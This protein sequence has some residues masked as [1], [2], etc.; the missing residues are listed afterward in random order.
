MIYT[1]T[2]AFYF[3]HPYNNAVKLYHYV[4]CP[5]CLRIRMVLGNLDIPWKSVPLDYHDEETPLRL[6]G[7]KMLPI[8]EWDSGERMNESLDI[9]ARLDSDNILGRELVTEE[10]NILLNQ[11][12]VPLFK[13]SMPHLIW[14]KEFNEKSRNYFQ[15]KKEKTRG[16]FLRLVAHQ[17]E[18]LEEL[19]RILAKIE[20]VLKN[21]TTYYASDKI[22]LPDI[23]LA[24]H[25]WSL[26]IVPEFQFSPILHNYL[27]KVKK[28]CRFNYQEDLW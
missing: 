3:F 22:T 21:S 24:S 17:Q 14:T 13:I 12:A 10:F 25:L 23:L 7:K 6:M 8:V 5:F 26:Y 9:M 2:L 19:N 28:E 4:H 20:P 27:Q 15:R 1:V 18:Y 16:S 11:L